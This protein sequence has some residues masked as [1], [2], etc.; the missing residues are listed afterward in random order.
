HRFARPVFHAGSEHPLEVLDRLEDGFLRDL[1]PAVDLLE[2]GALDEDVSRH[3]FIL[4][5]VDDALG[6]HDF[7]VFP[8]ESVHVALRIPLDEPP[9]STG[10]DLHLLHGRRVPL[11]SPPSRDQL[12]IGP[13]FPNERARRVEDVRGHELAFRRPRRLTLCGS[14]SSPTVA[15]PPANRSTMAR[16]MGWAKAAKIASRSTDALVRLTIWLSDIRLNI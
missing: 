12:R 5:G 10:A 3:P 2:R 11:R 6:R 9:G 14:A 15:S 7:L 13:R 4:E 8:V 1:R 16:R